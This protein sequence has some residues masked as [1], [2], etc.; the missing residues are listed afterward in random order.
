MRDLSSAEAKS[1]DSQAKQ[2]LPYYYSS[3]EDKLI[4]ISRDFECWL[5]LTPMTVR[6][7]LAN[8]LQLVLDNDI[9][10]WS[11]RKSLLEEWLDNEIDDLNAELDGYDLFADTY[12]EIRTS[13]SSSNNGFEDVDELNKLMTDLTT[14]TGEVMARRDSLKFTKYVCN[15][16]LNRADGSGIPKSVEQEIKSWVRLLLTYS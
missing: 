7:R 1:V 2:E 9:N 13:L 12:D 11:T 14:S 3:T 6:A 16:V 5:I 4:P 15:S 8:F 10:D